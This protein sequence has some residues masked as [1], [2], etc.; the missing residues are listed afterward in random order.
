[1]E[2]RHVVLQVPVGRPQVQEYVVKLVWPRIP[3][4]GKIFSPTNIFAMEASTRG[5]PRP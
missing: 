2:M 5:A 3:K 1:M 4:A